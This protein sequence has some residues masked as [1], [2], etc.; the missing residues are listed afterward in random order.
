VKP[1]TPAEALARFLALSPSTIKLG[2][3]RVRSALTALR[4]PEAKFPAV[5]VAGTNGKGSTCAF[6]ATCLAAHGY[7]VGLYTS[8]H[9]VKVNERFKINGEDIS[10]ELL[11]QRLFEIYQQLPEGLELTGF[12]VGTLVALW[13]F[14]QERVDVA[15]LETG[16]G[17][18]LDATTAA[19]AVVTAITPI[20]FDHTELLGSTLSAIAFEKAGILRAGVPVVVARQERQALEVIEREARNQG[21]RL[22]LEGRD[23]RFEPEPTGGRYVYRGMRTSVPR[24]WPGLRGAHQVQNAAVALAIL[25]LLEDRALPISQ[26]SARAGLAETEWPARLEDL[27]GTPRVVLDGAHNP[28]GAQVLAAALDTV[29]PGQDVHLVFG[30]LGDKDYRPMLRTLFPKATAV[31]LSPVSSP[32]SLDPAQ[33]VDEARTLCPNVTTHPSAHAALAAAQAAAGK[34]VVVCAGSLYFVGQLRDLL[35]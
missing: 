25:E 5:H 2:L 22:F 8:P 1:A 30:V 19:R 27:G 28:A 24:L 12:E 17:G 7:R 10:D 16:L 6:V 11:S 33:Y 31:Y 20:S 9:L 26:E 4:N 14:A 18:R 34:G 23:F 29:Y 15:V 35:T 13:H 3:D 21:A 32:R